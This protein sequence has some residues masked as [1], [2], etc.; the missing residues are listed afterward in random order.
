MRIGAV[1][2]VDASSASPCGEGDKLGNI[3]GYSGGATM[4]V[5]DVDAYNIYLKGLIWSIGIG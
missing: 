4:R 1:V 2:V 5:N 3:F